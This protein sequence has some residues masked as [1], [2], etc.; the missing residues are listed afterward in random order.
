MNA[1][2]LKHAG[3]RP[4]IIPQ[5]GGILV[6]DKPSGMTSHDVVDFVRKKFALKKVGHSGTLDPLATGVL[7]IL[8]NGFTK[9][10]S[11]L[12]NEDKEYSASLVLGKATDTFDAEG[13]LIKESDVTGL[14]PAQIRAA[15]AHFFGEIEQTPP[16]YSAL[17][18][19]G[20]KLYQLARK[21]VEVFRQPRKVTI[22]ELEITRM[23][24]PE[25]DFRLA[26]SKGTYV[27]SLAQ[28][29]GER[30]GCGAYLSALRRT[31]V[32]KFGLELALPLNE[33]KELSPYTLSKKLLSL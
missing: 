17:R 5:D 29:I 18:Y 21:G 7:L 10:A 28:A 20:K 26:C 1:D 11:R 4:Q 13:K 9:L 25:V 24:V 15:F 2:K 30:L 32:G 27:R 6:V 23:A 12:L 8:I 22:Y 19:Q 16:M 14:D 31:R 33:L 3:A